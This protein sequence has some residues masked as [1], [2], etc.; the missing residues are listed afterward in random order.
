MKVLIIP[1]DSRKDGYILN[2]IFRQLFSTLGRRKAKVKVCSDPVLGGVGEALKE[3][4]LREVVERYRG[5]V[6]V[7]I[8]CVD[9]DGEVDRR[10]RLKQIEGIF[11][12]GL[13]FLCE[14]AWEELE[15][16]LLAGLE[17]PNDWRWRDVRA[18][19]DV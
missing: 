12:D 2:P 17:L 18:E 1:E 4:R 5:M 11:G 19:V 8:L 6:D 10:D 14:N 9:R 7:F 16:W 15:T 3:Q 13:T